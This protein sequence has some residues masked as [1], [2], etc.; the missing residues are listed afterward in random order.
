MNR[1]LSPLFRRLVLGGAFLAATLVACIPDTPPVSAAESHF[2]EALVLAQADAK[3]EAKAAADAARDASREAAAAAREAAREAAE[4]TRKSHPIIDINIDDDDEPSGGRRKGV[5]IGIGGVDRHYDS[6][7]QFL[8]RDPALAAMVLGIVF[9]VFLTPILIIALIIWY[10]MRKNRMQNET[11]LKLAER[12]IVPAGEAMQA[13]G[14]GKV[15]AAIGVVNSTQ[16][17]VEQA[18]ALRKQAAWSDLRKGVLMG[19]VGLAI[20]FYTMI[21]EGSA[22]WFGLVLLFVGIGYCV[23]WY[24]EDRQ[25]TDART[26]FPVRPAGPGDTQN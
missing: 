15:D 22:N 21:N 4:A 9:I 18:R 19:A 1:P 6:F 11:M 24:F 20:T 8:D 10:K 16:P 3:A 17:L 12:G 5:N 2:R 7:D 26:A 25:V 13:I 23:L 14:T